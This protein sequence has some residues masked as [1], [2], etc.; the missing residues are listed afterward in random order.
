MKYSVI[1]VEDEFPAQNLL[2]RFNTAQINSLISPRPHLSL[3]GRYDLLTPE[4]GLDRINKELKNIYKKEDAGNAWVLKKYNT[5][6]YE[7]SIMRKEILSFLNKW[8]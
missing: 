7:T 1:I 2:K 8:L 4:A 6:H 3:A 5:G